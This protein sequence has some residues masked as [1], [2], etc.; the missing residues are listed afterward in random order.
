MQLNILTPK[1]DALNFM[2]AVCVSDRSGAQIAVLVII[3][4][5]IAFGLARWLWNK[6]FNKSKHKT[7]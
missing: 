3:S 4:A 6:Y 7:S 1:L 2:C 5:L